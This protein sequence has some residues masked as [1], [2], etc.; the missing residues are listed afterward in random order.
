[1]TALPSISSF[2]QWL[3]AKPAPASCP[4]TIVL[5]C[6]D[7]HLSSRIIVEL[8][9]YLNEY[10][11][12]SDGRWLP[13]TPELVGH[14]THDDNHR[15]LL[16]L[17]DPAATEPA[18]REAHALACLGQRGHVI[19]RAPNHLLPAPANPNSFHAGV[20]CPRQIRKNCHLILN[21][22]LMDQKSVAHIIGDV[23]LE[24]LH[25]DARRGAP[26]HEVR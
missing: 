10:D 25:C 22:A 5:H 13:A 3:H 7:P 18:A 26:L 23:F 21:S 19:F 24:W 4:C 17:P 12:E 1:M 16:G 14:I 6:N 15:Q 11:D 20:G 9:D 8:A 2:R